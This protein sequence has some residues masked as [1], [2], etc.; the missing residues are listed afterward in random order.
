MTLLHSANL[1]IELTNG[2]EGRSKKWFKSAAQR[3]Q[4][5]LILKCIGF[6]R[7][8]FPE[9]VDVR[10]TRIYGEGDRPWDPSSIGRGNYK[11]IEDSLVALGWWHDDSAKWIRQC[12]FRQHADR[13][14]KPA[15][16]IEVFA[17]VAD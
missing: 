6:A 11:E 10:V 12:D 14:E 5:Y 1:P 13:S 17:I 8:P 9:Q 4:Y 2:N 16:M 15:V 7:K 3:E